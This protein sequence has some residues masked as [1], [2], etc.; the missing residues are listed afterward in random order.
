M[1]K[2]ASTPTTQST[3]LYAISIG[4]KR[5]LLAQSGAATLENIQALQQTGLTLHSKAALT[6]KKYGQSIASARKWLGAAI[7]ESQLAAKKGKSKAASVD[8]DSDSD[9]SNDDAYKKALDHTPNEHSPKVLSLYLSYK[10]FHQGRKIGSADIPRAAFK[11]VWE[12]SDGST[13]RGRWHYNVNNQRWEGNP[14]ESSEV[15]DIYKAIKNKCGANGGERTH[16]LAMSKENMAQIIMWSDKV[17]LPTTYFSE[18]KTAQERSLRTKHLMFKAFSSTGWTTW[19]RNFELIKLREGDL[20]FDLEDPQAFNMPYFEL[21]LNNRKG[22]QKKIKIYYPG[23]KYKV[24]SQPDLPACDAY[25]W[26]PLWRK[27]L[28]EV[29]YCRALTPDDYIFPAIGANGVVQVGEHVSHDDV[30][31]LIKEFTAGAKL[32]QANGNFTTHCFRR[33]GAQYRFMFAPVGR[34]WTLRQL[35]SFCHKTLP[36]WR[37]WGGWADGEHRDTLIKYLLDELGTYEDDYSGMLLPN[38]PNSDRSLLGEGSSLTAATTGQLNLMHQALSADIR[39]VSGALTNLVEVFSKATVHTGMIYFCSMSASNVHQDLSLPQ[40]HP[41][42]PI[43]IPTN[44]SDLASHPSSSYIVPSFSTA[45]AITPTQTAQPP[46]L[47]VPD[48]P[49]TLPDGSRSPSRDSWKYA[50]LHWLEGD[51]AHGLH[52]P[53]K[54][55]PKEWFTGPNKRFAMKC[56]SRMVIAVEFITRYVC[57]GIA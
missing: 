36:P 40:T 14:V 50:V 55:W 47:V 3:A 30:Q 52:T 56:H 27:Y 11:D 13:Y 15:E 9:S 49:I 35:C 54:D 6:T 22:W 12:K 20:T 26:L 57:C 24:C 29:V 53:L 44:T 33:G 18:A 10:I 34:R 42:I 1:P 38:Q 4:K 17:C 31:K 8:D 45:S 28:Q 48:I 37:W 16:S 51:V 21:R 19:T 32:S 5:G 7:T 43:E 46:Y 25:H 39:T 23:G 41:I 2:A